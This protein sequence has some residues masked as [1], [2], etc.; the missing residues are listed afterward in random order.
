MPDGSAVATPDRAAKFIQVI[1]QKV[2]VTILTEVQS[3]LTL[4]PDFDIQRR[5]APT[6]PEQASGFLA[7][8]VVDAAIRRDLLPAFANAL[9]RRFR[10]NN[11]VL[12]LLH[13]FT[14]EVAPVNDTQ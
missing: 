4:V 7:K 3:E 5:G 8:L 14:A 11:E 6:A 1:A 2:P 10:Q 13:P 12:A 9:C